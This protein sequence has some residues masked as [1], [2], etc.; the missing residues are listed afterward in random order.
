[1]GG[2]LRVLSLHKSAYG[3]LLEHGQEWQLL[4]EYCKE[5]MG[6]S[7][8]HVSVEEYSRVL[9]HAQLGYVKMLVDI[10]WEYQHVC[11]ALLG[12][13]LICVRTEDDL[14]GLMQKRSDCCAT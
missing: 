1:M 3:C 2:T 13:Q 6:L 4:R 14:R 9:C 5:A 8:A 12:R 10:L 11:K 7:K